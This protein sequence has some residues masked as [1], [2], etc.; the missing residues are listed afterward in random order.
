METIR[1]RRSV[2]KRFLE[3]PVTDNVLKRILEAATWAPS[4]HNSQPWGFV[5]IRDN[6]MKKKLAENMAFVWRRDFDRDSTPIDEREMRIAVSIDRIS[7][8]PLLLVVCLLTQH[9]S[10]YANERKWKCEH[11][12][13]VQSVAAAIQNLLLA[14]HDLNLGSCWMCAPLFCQDTVRETLGIPEYAEPQA[15]ITLGYFEGSIE[16]P[17]R[18]PLTE[19]AHTNRW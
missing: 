17:P 3:K 4:A 9:L 16:A 19:I 7:N 14:A 5:A 6:A 11:T 1:G 8:A 10:K 12:M 15:L 13:A 2:K 18:K